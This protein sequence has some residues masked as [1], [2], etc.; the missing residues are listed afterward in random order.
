MDDVNANPLD[1]LSAFGLWP[2]RTLV[3]SGALAVPALG[4]ALIPWDGIAGIV[5]WAFGYPAFLAFVVM[6]CAIAVARWRAIRWLSLALIVPYSCIV[7]FVIWTQWLT[8]D[9]MERF[10][11]FVAIFRWIINGSLVG[12]A[13]V[14]AGGW[15][16]WWRAWRSGSSDR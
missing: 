8:V 2:Q 15:A 4:A 1:A 14:A 3:F 5:R 9:N 10:F 6:G 12:L 11:A 13:G 16:A 7:G